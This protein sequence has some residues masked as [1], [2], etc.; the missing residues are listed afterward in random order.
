M[1]CVLHLNA[2]VMPLQRRSWLNDERVTL[3]PRIARRE[4]SE[5]AQEMRLDMT[6]TLEPWRS[7]GGLMTAKALSRGAVCVALLLACTPTE[8][9][10][11]T[12][13]RTSVILYGEVRTAQGAPAA[14]AALQYVL[15]I[16]RFDGAD[17]CEFDPA[18]NDAEPTGA[19]ADVV[20][21][22]RTQIM[23]DFSPAIRCL[24]VTASS[25][26]GSARLDGLLVAFRPTRPDSVGLVLT[27]R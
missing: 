19:I 2:G 24:Q 20:G 3:R 7:H 23:S 8:P 17:L 22:F 21:R 15:S 18:R 12:S 1:R 10:A 25:A 27:L 5:G 9:C 11:C 14:G 13:P 26:A 4:P 16:R 6:G